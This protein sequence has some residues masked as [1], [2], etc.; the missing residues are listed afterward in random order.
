MT[1]TRGR[2]DTFAI[3]SHLAQ[4][5]AGSWRTKP[6]PYI[7]DAA[8]IALLTPLLI[9][10]GAGALGWRRLQQSPLRDTP[11][12]AVL[13]AAHREQALQAVIQE[14]KIAQIL[15]LLHSQGVEP[16]LIKGWSNA[17]LYPEPGLR[18]L[19]D[20]DLYIRPE[21]KEMT[22]KVLGVPVDAPEGHFLEIKTRLPAFYDLT[23]DDL[24]KSAQHIPL[25]QTTAL[26]PS[27]E[28]QLRILCLHFL[29]HGAWR[30][31]WLC[32]IAVV[33]ESRP[34]IFDWNRCLKPDGPGADWVACALGLAHQLLGA[35]VEDTPVA[36]RATR[37][38]AWLVPGVLKEWETP[39]T[40]L[41]R[42]PPA[43]LDT[44]RTPGQILPALAR[45]WP[46]PIEATLYL[47]ASLDSPTFP[48]QTRRF[49]LRCFQFLPRLLH[50]RRP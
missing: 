46:N 40:R 31:L 20:I 25:L 39:Q 44:L 2:T 21:H 19:G 3:G 8:Q 38:P 15:E 41:H 47:N 6:L 23:V 49:L 28:D 35:R 36:H 42:A 27:P 30:P 12:A 5:L 9:E 33:V 43:L 45:R 24:L 18:P 16:L 22:E 13:R 34:A 37:L 17:R 10:S 7:V 1:A 14:R 50:S 4:W 48:L 11:D 29:R 32:D 26:V